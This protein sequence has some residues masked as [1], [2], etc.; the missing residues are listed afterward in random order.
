MENDL[1]Q[2]KPLPLLELHREKGAKI[3]D[4]AGWEVP[5]Y[6]TSIIEEHEAVRNTAGLFDV[7][8]MGYFL[9]EGL[10]AREFLSSLLTANFDKL[11]PEAGIYSLMTNEAGGIIDDVI[12]Y[13]KNIHEYFL[14]VNASR[15]SEDWEWLSSNQK[16]FQVKLTDFSFRKTFFAL[17]GPK[18][19]AIITEFTG[20]DFSKVMRFQFQIFNYQGVEVIICRTGYTGEDGFEIL[21]P[22]PKGG[23]FWKGLLRVGEA[24]GLRPVGFGAR[25]SL[26]LEA[27]YSLYGH[28]LTEE[29]T[30]LEAGLS[31]AVDLDKNFIGSEKIKAQK[32]KG[33]SKRLIGFEALGRQ[34]PRAGYKLY[35]NGAESGFVTSGGMSP[36]LKKNIGLGYIDS[37]KPVIEGVEIEI[38]GQKIPCRIV[39]GPFYIGGSLKRFSKKIS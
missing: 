21:L 10:D 4:F 36:T 5:I 1:F 28:E 33:I 39:K 13:E 3:A 7:S 30:P 20:L 18:S 32:E 35:L 38:R 8:H 15:I 37:P 27:R 2:T 19:E 12:L 23:D 16:D 24:L 22:K 17:Q 26:R 9:I 34:I 6:F 25:D 29:V 31:W 11:K 14:V